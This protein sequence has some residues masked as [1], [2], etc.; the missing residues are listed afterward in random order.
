MGLHTLALPDRAAAETLAKAAGFWNTEEDC[1]KISG[2]S[3]DE[4]GTV[5]GWYIDD[6]GHVVITP[7]VM[8]EDGETM[9]TPA[10]M[11][12]EYYVNVTGQLPAPALAFE[13]PYGSAG[14]RKF[15]S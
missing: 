15:A 14:G 7:A 12:A 9:I 8:S 4:D 5:Y 3:T 2:Q 6:I 13:V 10:V 1:L 11:S